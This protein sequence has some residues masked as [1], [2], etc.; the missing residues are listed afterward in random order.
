MQSLVLSRF[1]NF[2]S[3]RVHSVHNGEER[4]HAAT[5]WRVK[6]KARKLVA[7]CMGGALLLSSGQAVAGPLPER[8]Q[9]KG[10]QQQKTVTSVQPAISGATATCTFPTAGAGGAAVT[11][12]GG[13]L[14]LAKESL[15]ATLQCSVQDSS[16]L[17]T[18]P[19]NL[20]TKVC[21]AKEQGSKAVDSC[22]IGQTELDG[23]ETDLNHLLGA[24]REIEWTKTPESQG[25]IAQATTAWNLKLLESDVPFSDKS[26]FVG[27]QET[28]SQGKN[29]SAQTKSTCT[30]TV[31]V[32]ARASSVG[33]N[34]VVTCA[35]GKNSNPKPLE[36]DMTTAN[37]TL[38]IDCGSEG[39]L[40]PASYETQFCDPQEKDLKNC[41]KKDYVDILPTFRTTWWTTENEGSSVKLTIPETEFPES[42]QT[43]RVACVP[44][45]ANSEESDP[46]AKA[47]ASE[48]AQTDVTTSNCNVVVT[49]KSGSAASSTGQLVATVSGAVA[50]LGLLL[51]SL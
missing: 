2:C 51:G 45:T 5:S 20:E 19:Q 35:Y 23:T 9:D 1:S 14:T 42:E 37:N 49:V 22:T 27:C 12:G 10:F 26:F 33:E 7:I 16:T 47:R 31:N 8:L 6:S 25:R 32:E 29:G 34:N 18:I 28:Q 36:V 3:I 48:G 38:T 17:S 41:A 39:S 40:S 46:A 21:V 13:I 50:L 24:K 30:V 44:R 15:S 11:P 4:K 43:F